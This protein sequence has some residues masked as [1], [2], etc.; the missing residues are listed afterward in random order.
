MGDEDDLAALP[1]FLGARAGSRPTDRSTRR[2]EERDEPERERSRELVTESHKGFLRAGLDGQQAAAVDRHARLAGGE[3]VRD[4][5]GR[6]ARQRLA[7]ERVLEPLGADPVARSVERHQRDEVAR[8]AHE[9][10]RSAYDVQVAVA[11]VCLDLRGRV[12]LVAEQE[13]DAEQVVEPPAVRADHDDARRLEGEGGVECEL[14]IRGVLC[15]RVPLDPRAGCLRGREPRGRDR[16]E[17]A[18]REID[19]QSERECAVDASVRGDHRGAGGQPR[20]RRA[21]SPG[22]DD[23]VRRTHALFLRWHY[24]D[25]VVRVGGAQS[26]PSQPGCPELPD[27]LLPS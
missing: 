9:P 19:A 6:P 7:Q 12:P 27:S 21:S 16:V 14:E 2:P 22:D 5:A 11:K 15:R 8:R 4:A 23:H 3:D 25:Q 26:P 10:A 20:H 18:D 17:V 13:R 24:P 1:A